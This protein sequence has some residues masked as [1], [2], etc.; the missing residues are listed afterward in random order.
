MNLGKINSNINYSNGFF[1]QL[2]VGVVTH[3][4]YRFS[5]MLGGSDGLDGLDGLDG[6]CWFT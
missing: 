1:H 3:P 4:K 5:M 6:A 2:S